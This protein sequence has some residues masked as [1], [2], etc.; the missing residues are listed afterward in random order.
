VTAAAPPI[1]RSSN[2]G[3]IE[4]RGI[5]AL[6]RSDL[7]TIGTFAAPPNISQP[8]FRFRVERCVLTSIGLAFSRLAG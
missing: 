4:T 5:C 2:Y 1:G 7:A 8:T 6:R 3:T